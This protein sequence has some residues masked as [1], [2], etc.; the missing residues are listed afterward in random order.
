[1]AP[2][3]DFEKQR[4]ENIQRNK[5]LLRKLNLDSI[6]DSISRELPNKK[7]S[8]GAK[9]RKTNNGPKS[10]KKE[11]QEPS[12]RSRR[13]A[14]VTMENT[15]EYQKAR[16]EMEKAEEKKREFEKLK[17]T[18]L[19]GNFHLIDLVTDKRLGDLKFEDKVLKLPNKVKE[20]NIKEEG[21][22]QEGI[23]KEDTDQVV[24]DDIVDI[25]EDNK[26]LEVLKNLGDKFSAGDFY[27]LIRE[28]TSNYDNK[29]LEDKRKE[30]DKLELYKRFDPLDIKITH[31]RITALNFHPSNTDRVI[32][33]GDKVGNLGIWAVD[34]TEDEAPAIT[35][36]KPH[37]KSI[38]RILTPHNS[39]SKIYSCAYDGSV[40]ELDFNKLV[41]SEIIYLKDPYESVDYPL[42]ISDINLC[43][44]GNPNILYMTTLSGNFQQHDLRVPYKGNKS[45]A[46]LRLH[47]KKIGSFCINPNV[48][49]QVATASLDRT[50][51]I[52]DLR[53]I[54]KANASWSEYDDQT[55]PHAYG[56]YSSRLSVSCVDWN[57]E[58]RLVCNGYDDTINIF[59]LNGQDLEVPVVNEWSKTFQLGAK[60]E[61]EPIPSNLKPFTK[62]KHNCQTG[63]WVSILKS[64]WQ[65]SPKDGVQKFIIAN[66]N[67]GLD[68]YDQKGQI[69]AH[70]TD[71]DKVGAV[72]AV[73]AFH[74]VENW[75]VGG[76][77]SGKLYLFE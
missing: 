2:L 50:M 36:L 17:Q 19:F 11:A 74:P 63:R 45:N 9:K 33:A 4:Q 49:H 60:K 57:N 34:S 7:Q 29:A 35:I 43:Q 1:M 3:S 76:S 51:K 75:C 10:I 25:E 14:G 65:T 31:Q 12:R 71:R 16:E 52:W 23:K 22:K 66:M 54:S 13:L 24:E 48:S 77:A 41:S 46:L 27:D 39:P 47:D 58:N 67:R 55:S 37:G 5:D 70:L 53:N 20:E 21:V 28:S 40:R 26:V 72:P 30:F 38:S 15:E 8:N 32:T 42:G 73:T 6:T 62:I 61:D 68:I 59:D 64:K 18:R 44:E 69:L 56:S